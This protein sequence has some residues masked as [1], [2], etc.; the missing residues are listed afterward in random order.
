MSGGAAP[1]RAGTGMGT[2]TRP[3]RGRGG[4]A[5]VRRDRG[6]AAGLGNEAAASGWLI[7][8]CWPLAAPGQVF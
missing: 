3:E 6:L 5:E 4:S 1:G 7:A 8:R 2:G